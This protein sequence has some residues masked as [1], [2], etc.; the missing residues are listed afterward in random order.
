MEHKWNLRDLLGFCL[1]LHKDNPLLWLRL[2]S[3][4]SWPCDIHTVQGNLSLGSPIEQSNF[5]H[6]PEIPAEGTIE[7]I[8]PSSFSSLYR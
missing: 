2:C 7:T 3:P 8:S 4:W 5:D 1:P 6:W